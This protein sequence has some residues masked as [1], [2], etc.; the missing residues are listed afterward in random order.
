M[1]GRGAEVR[2]G[3]SAMVEPDDRVPARIALA[4]DGEGQA[5]AV[6]DHERTGGIE[7]D[8]DDGVRRHTRLCARGLDRD[9]DRRPDVF[10]IMLGVVF[11]RPV[12]QNGIIG[13][14]QQRAFRIEDAGTRTPCA[15]VDGNDEITHGRPAGLRHDVAGARPSVSPPLWGRWTAVQRGSL[16]AAR[17]SFPA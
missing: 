9:A 14:R 3:K 1:L 16:S 12:H 8:R 15:N 5:L 6:A 7:A 11:F 13:T 10:G 4:V 2:L 17:S